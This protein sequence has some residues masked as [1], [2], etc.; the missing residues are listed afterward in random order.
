MSESSAPH[1]FSVPPLSVGE[2]HLWTARLDLAEAEVAAFRT[3]IDEEE[4][5][6]AD[7]FHFD[8][9]RRRFTI[10]RGFQRVVL[11]AYLDKDPASIRYR[12]G[13]K[14]K[15]AL[16]D[17]V[18]RGALFFNLSNSHDL[19]LLALAREQEIG[20]DLEHVRDVADLESLA[21]RNFSSGEYTKL[22]ALPRHLHQEAFF[23]CWTRKEA[24]LKAVGDGL[25]APLDRFEVSLGPDESARMLTLEGSIDRASAWTLFDLQPAQGYFGAI[26]IEGTNWRM[27]SFNFAI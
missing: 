24:Y 22:L 14:G 27:S 11:G 4:K 13:P 20:V 7:H 19:A 3:L 15:P 12:H 26:A 21:V 23:R 1:R 18:Q 16:A 8:V 9:H 17:F 25:S 6:R 2:V 5:A 10:G